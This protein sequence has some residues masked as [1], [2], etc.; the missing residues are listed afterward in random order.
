MINPRSLCIF[1]KNNEEF[2]NK[3]LK[4]WDTIKSGILKAVDKVK[5]WWEENGETIKK[6]VVDALQLIATIVIKRFEQIL[7]VAKKVWPYI[8]EVI[9][10][11]IIAF[12]TFI[13]VRL[14]FQAQH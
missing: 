7:N 11:V 3:V 2:R 6:A 12:K 8:K 4:L 13:Y 14:I 5:S 10:D 9:I 1:Y